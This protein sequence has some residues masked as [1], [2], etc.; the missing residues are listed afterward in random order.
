MVLL[1]YYNN[2]KTNIAGIT[3]RLYVGLPANWKEKNENITCIHFIIVCEEGPEIYWKYIIIFETKARN[4][5]HLTIWGVE[6]CSA[7]EG[8]DVMAETAKNNI[9]VTENE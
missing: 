1:F 3:D 7:V 2:Y 8:S 5:L 4:Y 9:C 6:L